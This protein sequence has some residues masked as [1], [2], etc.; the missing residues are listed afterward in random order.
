MTTKP[1]VS[2]AGYVSK[3]SDY[4]HGCAFDPKKSCPLTPMYWAFL[5][6]NERALADQQ[7]M[8]V[9]LAALRKRPA[10]QRARDVQVLE[11][12]RDRLRRGEPVEPGDLD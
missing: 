9:P 11:A 2:G 7:R 5:G 10:A 1:Y 6:R 3:M 4:C 8:A 12:V